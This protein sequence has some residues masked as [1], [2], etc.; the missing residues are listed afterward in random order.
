VAE[1]TYTVLIVDDYEADR[2]FLK[3]TIRQHAPKLHVVAEVGDGEQ[4]VAYLSGEGQFANRKL[5]PLPDV[6][7]LDVRM[8][9]MTGLEVLE[10]LQKQ[11]FP[12][13]KIAMMADSSSAIH[14]AKALAL[15]VE[16]F[17]SKIMGHGEMIVLVKRLQDELERGERGRFL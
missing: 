3:E 2:F 11:N 4:A 5:H 13:L 17:Y 15:G 6:M 7:I 16:H 12:Q 14:R 10:W 9:R 1:K 8:P